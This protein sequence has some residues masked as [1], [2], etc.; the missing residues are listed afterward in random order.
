MIHVLATVTVKSGCRERFLQEFHALMPAVHAE[1]GCIAYAPAID[2]KS[3][4]FSQ[5]ALRTD[6]VVIIEQW[7]NLDSL[8]AHLVA[9]HMG[10]YRER[11]KDLVIGTQLQV[12]EPA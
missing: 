12:L 3:G 2:V 5:P 8:R 9:P 6:V 1:A 4:L 11:V 10:D 7:E